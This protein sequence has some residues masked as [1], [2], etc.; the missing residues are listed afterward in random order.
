MESKVHAALAVPHLGFSRLRASCDFWSAF[1]NI[2][3]DAVRRRDCGGADLPLLTRS[4]SSTD[5][6][7]TSV[8]LSHSERAKTLIRGADLRKALSAGGIESR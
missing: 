6:L 1:Q 5:R 8:C 2:G 7:E 4:C 3:F